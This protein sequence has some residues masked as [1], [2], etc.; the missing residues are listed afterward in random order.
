M[1]NYL[2]KVM[3]QHPAGHRQDNS[4]QPIPMFSQYQNQNRHQ[5]DCGDP[6]GGPSVAQSQHQID[7]RSCEM[8]MKPSSH[9]MVDNRD[10]IDSNKIGS[11]K[12]KH[13]KPAD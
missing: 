1:N 9:L 8:P 7:E 3:E 2:D 4:E 10:A 5:R 11:T 6:E 12:Q 13:H